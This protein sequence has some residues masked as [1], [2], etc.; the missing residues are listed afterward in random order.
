MKKIAIIKTFDFE[1]L[2]F[3]CEKL[4][5]NESFCIN[6]LT[7]SDLI[8]IEGKDKKLFDEIS[9]FI[10]G[11]KWNPVSGIWN[12][13]EGN[14]S[15]ENFERNTLYSAKYFK[16]K[17]DKVYKI[18]YGKKILNNKFPTVLYNSRFNAAIIENENELYW[19]DSSDGLRTL[20]IGNIKGTDV[21]TLTDEDFASEEFTTLEKFGQEVFESSFDVK[22]VTLS[23]GDIVNDSERNLIKAEKILTENFVNNQEEIK[24]LWIEIFNNNFENA[25][26]F[27]K[28][29]FE[30]HEDKNI[31]KTNDESII[32]TELKFAEN[33]DDKIIRVKNISDKELRGTVMCDEFNAGFR[34][35]IS[36]FE[37][38]TFRINSE[39]FVR[40][41]FITE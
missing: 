21:D 14:I 37:K 28:E 2:Y 1:K 15:E 27:S 18:Y 41:T 23:E 20:I 32:I 10:C 25:D 5:Q 8:E 29:V 38:I 9:E 30:K 11:G 7:A 40:E 36:P 39:G 35:E 12:K 13:N 3:I 6:G 4:R 33:S 22:T 31:I 26:K 16:E 34:F 19:L 24:K 17:F